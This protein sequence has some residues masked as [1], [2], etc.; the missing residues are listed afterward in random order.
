MLKIKIIKQILKTQ[1]PQCLQNST[2][3]KP[4]S[5]SQKPKTKDVRSRPNTLVY[6]SI[7]WVLA[8]AEHILKLERYREDC[9]GPRTRM[10]HKSEKH[11]MF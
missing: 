8:L 4:P 9:H 6:K 7:L 2:E 3:E 5:R 1:L 10:T 11:S